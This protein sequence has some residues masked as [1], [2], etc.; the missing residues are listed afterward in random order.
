M[1]ILGVV[2]LGLAENGVWA[3]VAETECWW[4]VPFIKSDRL[5][6]FKHFFTYCTGVVQLKVLQLWSELYLK[7]ARANPLP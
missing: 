5:R 7:K 3:L 6:F 1:L 2:H 4:F